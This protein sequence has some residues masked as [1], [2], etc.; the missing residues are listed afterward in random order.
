MSFNV[1]KINDKLTKKQ[2]LQI[3]LTFLSVFFVSL[4]TISFVEMQHHNIPLVNTINAF[5]NSQISFSQIIA[6]T[7]SLEEIFFS[8]T[9][10]LLISSLSAQLVSKLLQ[11]DAKI[12]VIEKQRK[13]YQ[14]HH[15]AIDKAAI[16]VETLPD[17]MITLANKH[18]R[19]ISGY[20]EQELLGKNH[21][22]LK[23][24]KHT[25]LFYKKLWKTISSG[26][27]WH[28]ELCNRAKDGRFYWV[29]A[30]IV[31]ILN[32]QRHVEK[33]IAIHFDITEQK[34]AEL[35]KEGLQHQL[36]H[37]QKLDSIGQLTSGIAHDFNNILMGISGY[38]DLAL[39]FNAQTEDRLIREKIET[40]LDGI[41]ISSERASDL[42]RKMLTYCQENTITTSKSINP[43]NVIQEA[44]DMLRASIYTSISIDFAV[45][46]SAEIVIDSTE[47]HQ[48]I[49]N[50]IVN[51]RDAIQSDETLAGKILVTVNL[52]DY[53]Q[54]HCSACLK[55]LHHT[56][57]DI[58]VSDNGSG[59]YPEQINRIFD[60][61]F[62]TKAVGKGTGL[63]LSVVSGIVHNA[64]G[65]IVVESK[66]GQGSQFHLLFPLVT[67]I[68][69]HG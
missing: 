37:S 7:N 24:G 31:P 65:H 43:V 40:Y 27:V 3:F 42:V 6:Q 13:I 29:N 19:R 21:R 10:S 66:L 46:D 14:E 4:I 58:C 56:Y 30:T 55:K 8:V 49:T 48:L 59:I 15:L 34:N 35:E 32:E 51:A 53:M 20:S 63:G 9:I 28:G 5:Q 44:L 50:L 38:T 12:D 25:K 22:I 68:F 45:K 23:S 39:L 18:F 64:E 33:Y 67:P 57:V 69:K 26:K 17:G 11:L 16:F 1:E 2:Q 61:F 52:H 54:Q 62:T 36:F 60:P 41:Q 47:L